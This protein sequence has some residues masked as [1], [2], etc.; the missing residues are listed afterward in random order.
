MLT[1]ATASLEYEG[2]PYRSTMRTNAN[3]CSRRQERRAFI[4]RTTTSCSTSKLRQLFRPFT[5]TTDCRSGEFG[6]QLYLI[7]KATWT[8]DESLGYKTAKAY[9]CSLLGYN[10]PMSE[11]SQRWKA[12]DYARNAG[13]VAALGE[14]VLELLAPTSGEWILDLGCGDGVLT[15]KLV[16]AGAHVIGVDHSPEMIA[17]SRA[18]GI[19]ARIAD[20]I[21][22]PFNAEF[23]A[24]FTN[25]TLHWVKAHPDAA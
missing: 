13:F 25:A 5:I 14:P 19:D 21:A 18:L 3:V 20:A 1:A 24:V 12:Q 15:K 8:S 4:Q 10:L 6:S 23:D 17:A 7:S 16:A 11:T 2:Q 9:M 22:L